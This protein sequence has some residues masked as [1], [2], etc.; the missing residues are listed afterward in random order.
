M[1]NAIFASKL[2]KISSRKDKLQ[3]AISNPINAELVKQLNSYVEEPEDVSKELESVD[4]KPADVQDFESE[5]TDTSNTFIPRRSAVSEPLESNSTKVDE[6]FESKNTESDEV[7]YEESKENEIV[8]DASESEKEDELRVFHKT[9]SSDEE[10]KDDSEIE[11]ST[12]V[13]STIVED[14]CCNIA[15]I[16]AEILKG[17]LNSR[18]DTKGVSRV[19]VKDSEVWIYYQDKVNLNNI[20][21]PAIELLG[22]S[23]FNH[24]EFNRLA[25]SSN[26]IV[27]EMSCV[28]TEYPNSS[29]VKS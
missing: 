21:E 5:E 4:I 11:E 27:F 28:P 17:T 25:R 24:L 19:V 12:I 18:E 1:M 2:Y 6:E 15:K 20:M 10:D 9:G 29:E 8:D 16:D 23:G 13:S 3:A 7:E 14:V 22:V 26:A